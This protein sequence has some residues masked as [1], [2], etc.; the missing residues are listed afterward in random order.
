M[1]ANWKQKGRLVTLAAVLVIALLVPF[2]FSSAQTE[3]A[4]PT[5]FEAVLARRYA[6]FS[7]DEQL[8]LLRAD[9]Q[10]LQ[11]AGYHLCRPAVLLHE[12][13]VRGA[14]RERLDRE[15]S[16]PGEEVEDAG[17][18]EHIQAA[19]A[20]AYERIAFA[21]LRLGEFE[22]AKQYY[23]LAYSYVKNQDDTLDIVHESIYKA[24]LAFQRPKKPEEI[25]FS[26]RFFCA[27]TFLD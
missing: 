11:V 21:F 1:I 22:R 2:L 18:V 6:S 10:R 14:A 23:R 9:S 13:G 17:A 12:R 5:D 20:R 7:F 19:E 15:R 8:R 3:G 24:M 25:K 4:L 16:G 27:L 26:I